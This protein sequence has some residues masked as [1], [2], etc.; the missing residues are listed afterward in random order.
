ME[1]GLTLYA[2]LFSFIMYVFIMN[3][4]PSTEGTVTVTG[5]QAR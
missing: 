4:T 5:L 3:N 2:Y 1:V